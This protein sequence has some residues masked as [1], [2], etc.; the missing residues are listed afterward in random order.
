[1]A[2]T[3]RAAIH[4]AFLTLAGNTLAGFAWLTV[5]TSRSLA[6]PATP[7]NF[8]PPIPPGAPIVWQAATNQ[9]PATLRCYQRIL[10]RIFPDQTISKALVLGSLQSNKIAWSASKELCVDYDS[11]PCAHVCTFQI[12]PKFARL[13]YSSPGFR[14]GSSAQLPDNTSLVKRAQAC[15]AQLGLDLAQLSTKAI[16]TNQCE[17]DLQGRQAA[18]NPCSL[19]ITL[20]RRIDGIEFFGN[21]LVEGFFLD[22]GSSGYVRGFALVWS[23]LKPLPTSP[24]ASPNQ[25]I[26]CMRALKVILLPI[27]NEPDYFYRLKSFARAKKLTI[28]KI[29]PRFMEGVFGELPKETNGAE[30]LLSPMA[31]LEA[32]AEFEN[33]SLTAT[34]VTPILASDVTR[35]LSKNK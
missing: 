25:L 19:A 7:Q 22:L 11:G 35:L 12:A 28:T 29:T 10:P 21:D 34:I 27:E 4:S 30:K 16:I 13:A 15:A 3:M 5:A 23:E 1:M 33:S 8:S 9:L 32:V 26:D 17:F 6:D 18:N 31:E 14:R 20:S 24:L 2:H